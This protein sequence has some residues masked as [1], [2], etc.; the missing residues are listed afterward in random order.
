MKNAVKI[1][2]IVL[3]SVFLIISL[4]VIYNK[5]TK[6]SV[7]KKDEFKTLFNGK[8]LSCNIYI[9]SKSPGLV[10]DSIIVCNKTKSLPAKPSFIFEDF[11]S[12]DSFPNEF[13]FVN[14]DT[15][16]FEKLNDENSPQYILCKTKQAY[17]ILTENFPQK[18]ITYVGFTSIDRMK[19]G[20]QMDYN[21]FIHICGKSP[22][23]GTVQLIKTWVKNPDFPALK[24]SL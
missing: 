19:E 9:P 5:F 3:L 8:N 6:K 18:E 11:D 2:F 24:N 13:I 12:E 7:E 15:T 16:N 23:K 17:D 20:F 22:F 10:L 14:M 1:F 4:I 21:K